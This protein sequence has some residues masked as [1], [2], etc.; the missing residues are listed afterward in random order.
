MEETTE[1]RTKLKEDMDD[2]H[3]LL[4]G[5]WIG[6]ELSPKCKTNMLKG[7]LLAY[8][9]TLCDCGETQNLAGMSATTRNIYKS[10]F[11]LANNKPKKV[12]LFWQF[13]VWSRHGGR[14]FSGI[15]PFLYGKFWMT[16]MKKRLLKLSAERTKMK[17]DK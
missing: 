2:L 17:M 3:I 6:W 14:I 9:N 8:N 16:E 1:Q 5:P 10:D 15:Q 12:A 13:K 7:K 4:V 11:F